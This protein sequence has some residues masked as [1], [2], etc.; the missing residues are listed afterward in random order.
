LICLSFIFEVEARIRSPC[1]KLIAY[2]FIYLKGEIKM[3]RNVTLEHISR[4]FGFSDG[5]FRTLYHTNPDKANDIF[6]RNDSYFMS[7]QSYVGEVQ[8][9][10][11]KMDCI[12]REYISVYIGIIEDIGLRFR[13]KK[14]AIDAESKLVYK[15]RLCDRDFISVNY[16]VIQRWR[17]IIDKF[18][19]WER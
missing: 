17:I 1:F 5:Y 12:L 2:V 4:L 3:D 14:E 16:N 9:L 10:I 7:I 19:C 11:D 15:A 13:T 8:Q 6:G 18:E